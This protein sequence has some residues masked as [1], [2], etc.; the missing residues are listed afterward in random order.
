MKTVVQCE[1]HIGPA[2]IHL[3]KAAPKMIGMGEVA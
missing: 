3:E 2:Q 1:K